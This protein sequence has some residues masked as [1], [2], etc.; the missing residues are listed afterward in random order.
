[1][2]LITFAGPPSSGKTSVIIRTIE[3]L[4]KEFSFGV[5]K[6]DCLSSFDNLLYEKYNIPVRIGL[7]GN[8]CP[9]HFFISNI[10]S[11]LQWGLQSGFD[12]LI[13]ESAGLC[14]RCSPHIRDVPAVCI[15][16]NL[17]GIN[18]PKK[19]GP[20][21]RY[22]DVVIITKGDI[23]SQ[24]E[25]EVFAFNVR[26][27]NPRA[28]TLFVNGITGQGAFM[29]SRYIRS[30]PDTDSLEDRRLRFTMPAALCSYCLGET[31]IGEDFLMGSLRRMQFEQ[32]KG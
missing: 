15:I 13:T 26:K 11:G 28:K 16:D 2:K 30:A 18:T 5:I 9:D 6:F 23:V 17:S 1:M 32:E 25:R 12:V 19:I 31:R 22:A 27:A 14:N 24:A 29:L 4:K 20:M 8:L 10:E 21:L 3:C 7:S